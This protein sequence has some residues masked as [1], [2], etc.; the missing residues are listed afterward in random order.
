MK[1]KVWLR[2]WGV[3]QSVFAVLWRA[4]SGAGAWREIYVSPGLHPEPTLR[5]FSYLRAR[6]VRCRLRN[7]ISSGS[8]PE[9]TPG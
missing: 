7:L 2:L 8:E 1:G 3:V 4:M 9:D 6:G 5:R